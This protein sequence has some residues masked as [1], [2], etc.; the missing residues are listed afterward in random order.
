[1]SLPGRRRRVHEDNDANNESDSSDKNDKVMD[2]TFNNV[3]LINEVIS[4]CESFFPPIF[5]SLQSAS[6]NL[7]KH[8]NSVT[9]NSQRSGYKSNLFL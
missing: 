8:C 5:C 9:C 2:I 1:M 4:Y 3:S 6:K 7:I